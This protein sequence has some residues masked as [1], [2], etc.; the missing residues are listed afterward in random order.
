MKKTIKCLS[1][2]VSIMTCNKPKVISPGEL[3]L[4]KNY[5]NAERSLKEDHYY[6]TI[7]EDPYRWLENDE[8][9][10]TK[11]WITAENDLTS[12]YLAKI[13]YRGVVPA[14]SLKFSARSQEVQKGAHPVLLRIATNAGPGAGTSTA[15]TIEEQ[16]DDGLWGFI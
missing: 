1:I 15:M 14:H 3:T 8:S 5:P 4:I 10:K 7:V 12:A 13:P 2:V 9:K 11:A 16:T 6:G